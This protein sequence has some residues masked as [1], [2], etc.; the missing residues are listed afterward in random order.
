MSRFLKTPSDRVYAALVVVLAICGVLSSV[1]PGA[2][3]AS[4][5]PPESKPLFALGIAAIMLFGY[6]GLGLI[7]LRF[8]ERIGFPL[9]W[10]ARVSSRDRFVVPAVVGGLV[11]VCLIAGDRTFH[12]RAAI[13]PLPHPNFP[14]SIFASLSAGIGEELIFRLFFI[15]FWMWLVSRLLLNGRTPALLFWVVSAVS[16]LVFGLGHLPALQY[17]LHYNSM[18]DLPPA[19]FT[20]VIVLNGL[21][22]LA[23][24]Y[25]FRKSG[26][27]AAIGVHFWTDVVWHVFWGFMIAS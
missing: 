1:L 13:P 3:P 12:S 20:E 25:Y 27:L 9:L 21:V 2:L 18:A 24:A 16:A 11:G 22:G 26:Y 8:A 23:T 14:V 10:D 15:S 6:G 7:G 5:Q 17:L 19:L 4:A